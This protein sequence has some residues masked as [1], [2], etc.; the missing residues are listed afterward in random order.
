VEER[1]PPLVENLRRIADPRDAR[2]TAEKLWAI[3]GVFHARVGSSGGFRA[4]VRGELVRGAENIREFMAG[5]TLQAQ[6]EILAVLEEGR[7]RGDLRADLNPAA[8]A[9]FLVRME[10]EI[11]DL[12]PA[13]SARMSGQPPERALPAT[14]R[15]WFELFWRGTAA[16][17]AAPLPELPAFPD[18]RPGIPS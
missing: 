6:K 7:R 13:M 8:L 9:F 2:G 1:F 17:P 18:P 10:M 15:A 4:M 14:E 12:V 3:L 11:L 5:W 16:H